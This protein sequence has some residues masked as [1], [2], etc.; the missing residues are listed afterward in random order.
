VLSPC[1]PE[2]CFEVFNL[3]PF[4]RFFKPDSSRVN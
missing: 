4:R 3:Q 1:L 2:Y